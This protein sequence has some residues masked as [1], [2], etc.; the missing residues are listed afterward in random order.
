MDTSDSVFSGKDL[1][2][3]MT[4]KRWEGSDVPRSIIEAGELFASRMRMTR[5]M[6]Q[7]WKQR[8]LFMKYDRGWRGDEEKS[9]DSTASNVDDYDDL[10]DPDLR[11]R[12][13][14]VEHYFHHALA[15]MQSLVIVL[16]KVM[17]SNVQDIAIRNG[18]LTEATSQPGLSR[19]KSNSNVTNQQM[20]MPPPP[21]KPNEMT[22]EDLDNV[23]SR[24]ISQKAISG[25]LFLL[26]KWFKISHVLKFEYLTQ[27]LLDSN[28][29][30]L[31]LKYFAH[32]NLE[33]LV[34][35]K[36]DRPE[37]SFFH[38]CHLH[39]DHPPLSP[40]SPK[41]HSSASSIDD[42]IPPPIPRHR[43]SSGTTSNAND[44]PL[45]EP[46]PPSLDE[47]GNPLSPNSFPL[48]PITTFSFRHLFTS[49]TLLRILQKLTSR[50]P[51]RVLLLVQFRSSQILRR[52]L[53]VPEPTL[54]LYTL[55]L[56]KS[57]VPYCPRKWRQSNMRVITAVYLHC[58]P[59]LR[60][61]W[62]STSGTGGP[63]MGLGMHDGTGAE[64][65]VEESLSVE[66]GWRGLTYWW[67][68]REYPEEMRLR[69]EKAGLLKK[70]EEKVERR[71]DDDLGIELDPELKLASL[72]EIDD[73]ER[74]FF[75]RE[76]DLLGWGMAGLLSASA[77]D[78]DV[79]FGEEAPGANGLANG[80]GT[81]GP[82]GL[83]LGGVAAEGGMIDESGRSMGA[84]VDAGE[85]FGWE[86]ANL[87]TI[88]AW[89]EGR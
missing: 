19:T 8:D 82:E 15:D 20:P 68:K 53:R 83:A 37:L 56:F 41:S 29:V 64:G 2:D 12:M 39:S 23:R 42:A 1:S 55:K 75:Q 59:E 77:G 30:Q 87:G 65:E 70:G 45:T 27:L 9:N 73:D 22:I 35:F 21:T 79:A 44:P 85:R 61:E 72:Q 17:L 81:I 80:E 31:T 16:M 10:K 24:E 49:T 46:G 47:L 32:Q 86:S 74:D 34:A 11:S 67:L 88:E 76:L 51:H 4:D 78:E 13:A 89:Q 71:D 69:D 6:R 57:Q 40:T 50:K 66:W 62:L 60:D 26:L 84:G 52:I 48:S 18:N 25:T 33:D 38:Y 43:R 63:G 36:Y 7:L 28:Y 5:A 58:R 3:M 54:R 14:A